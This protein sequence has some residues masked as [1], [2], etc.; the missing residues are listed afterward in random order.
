[1]G[2]Y[3]KNRRPLWKYIVW[4]RGVLFCFVSFF[5]TFGGILGVGE[6]GGDSGEYVRFRGLVSPI[7]T[8]L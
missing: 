8:L 7:D 5:L 6:G 4:R 2:A 1:M 3:L